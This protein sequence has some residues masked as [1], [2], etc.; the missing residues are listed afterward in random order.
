MTI[1][2][3]NVTITKSEVGHPQLWEF[4][5]HEYIY[6]GWHVTSNL[7]CDIMLCGVILCN[8]VSPDAIHDNVK[9]KGSPETNKFHYAAPEFNKE[10]Q[11]R[12]SADI[13]SFGI[14][15]LE[16]STKYNSM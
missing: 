11:V 10:T 1:I 13:F 4:K 16:V 15:A 5:V 12:T 7:L 14:C 2:V 8:T 9:T 3:K 6:Y